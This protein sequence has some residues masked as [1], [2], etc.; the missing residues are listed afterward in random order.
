MK[1]ETNMKVPKK[2]HHMI[3]EIYHDS[4]GYWCYTA[5]GFYS[6]YMDCHTIHEDTQKQLLEV[7]RGIEPCDCEECKEEINR[8]RG[9][10][11]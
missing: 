2:Y 4:D 6:P 10:A 9:K 1:N 11:K 5:D 7:I 8:K 3:S